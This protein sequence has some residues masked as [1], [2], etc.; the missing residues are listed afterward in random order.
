MASSLPALLQNAVDSGDVKRTR[1]VALEALRSRQVFAG[2]ETPL[3]NTFFKFISGS[4]QAPQLVS[5]CAKSF[6]SDEQLEAPW[7]GP[8]LALL[9]IA[10]KKAPHSEAQMVL[11]ALRTEYAWL[12]REA[13]AAQGLYPAVFTVLLEIIKRCLKD[14][15]PMAV[16][17][18]LQTAL[19]V[20]DLA[21]SLVGKRVCAA[22][23]FY[24]A[25][26]LLFCEKLEEAARKFQQAIEFCP[27]PKRRAQILRFLIPLRLATGSLPRRSVVA[28]SGL[29]REWGPV[30]CSV[31]RGDIFAVREAARIFAEDFRTQEVALLFGHLEL[32]ACRFLFSKIAGVVGKKIPIAVLMAGLTFAA[33]ENVCEAEA[34]DLCANLISREML[35]GYLSFEEGVLVL[36]AGQPFPSPLWKLDYS[37]I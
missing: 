30:V 35:S 11:D 2:S 31:K 37:F 9:Q 21:V 33:K 18:L 23:E 24:W 19:P 3:L 7:A 1:T 13:R 32:V 15:Q 6:Q 14:K 26:H 36:S 34:L 17:P 12:R 29:E 16:D 4:V 25:R 20:D 22:L 10:C 8:V 5:A 27:D 28:S